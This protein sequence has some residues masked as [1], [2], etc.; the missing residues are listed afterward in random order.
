MF[1]KYGF[2]IAKFNKNKLCSVKHFLNSYNMFLKYALKQILLIIFRFESCR[3]LFMYFTLQNALSGVEAI[4][5]HYT[6]VTT[7]LKMVRISILLV[8][9]CTA[10]SYSCSIEIRRIIIQMKSCF[11]TTGVVF[12]KKLLLYY[13]S[14]IIIML[15]FNQFHFLNTSQ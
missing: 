14:V 4:D 8:P 10:L 12:K 1:L 6:P 2:N 15:I 7:L 3:S 5:T 9:Y 11:N 13:F